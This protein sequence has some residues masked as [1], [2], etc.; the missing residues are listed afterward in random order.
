ML[1]VC[2]GPR[3]CENKARERE[4]VCVKKSKG[5]TERVRERERE[6]D[7]EIFTS[8]DDAMMKARSSRSQGAIKRPKA[9]AFMIIGTSTS[10]T[11]PGSEKN[12]KVGI[13]CS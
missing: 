9:A 12:R 10:A 13:C 5:K 7:C 8:V 1:G 2:K 6:R 11:N 3:E 4:R